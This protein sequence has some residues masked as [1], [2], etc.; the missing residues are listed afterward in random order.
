VLLSFAG[1]GNRAI[2]SSRTLAAMDLP[3]P[4][5]SIDELNEFLEDAF[6]G[7]TRAYRVESFTEVGCRLRQGVDATNTRPGGTISGPTMMGLA[8]AAAWLATLSRIGIVPLAVTSNLTINF[9]AKP[10]L[11]DL[12]AEAEVLRLGKRSSIT[13][14][15]V[16]S[17]DTLVAQATVGYSIP[18]DGG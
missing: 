9:L 2:S 14:V 17:D 15:R 7:A 3:D 10:G 11:A 1:H 18:S 4:V 13:D 6:P 5:V 12:V 16:F 8:D